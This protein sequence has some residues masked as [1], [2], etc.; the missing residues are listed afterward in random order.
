MS[1]QTDR[2]APDAT[3]IPFDAMV[4]VGGAQGPQQPRRA[5]LRL[6]ARDQSSEIERVVAPRTPQAT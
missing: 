2:R 1:S 4:E 3:R 5:V 6:D